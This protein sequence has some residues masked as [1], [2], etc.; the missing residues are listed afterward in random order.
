[1]RTGDGPSLHQQKCVGRWRCGS[2]MALFEADPV[3]FMGNRREASFQDIREFLDRGA[4][5]ADVFLVVENTRCSDRFRGQ[6]YRPRII[7]MRSPCGWTCH[8]QGPLCILW[9]S[10]RSRHRDCLDY[11]AGA[12]PRLAVSTA[13]T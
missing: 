6:L 7:S 2:P 9:I 4:A 5:R 8:P 3:R 11:A 13:R 10:A 12:A 1:V